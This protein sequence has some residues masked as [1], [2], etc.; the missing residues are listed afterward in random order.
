MELVIKS[1]KEL[2]NYHFNIPNFQR[3][4]RWEPDNVEKLLNDIVDF[5]Q[6]H[7][8]GTFYFYKIEMTNATQFKLYE[9]TDNID[10]TFSTSAELMSFFSKYKDL[11]FFYNKDEEVYNKATK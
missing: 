10:E 2:L 3:G 6:N 11:S 9:V 5:H 7:Q 8:D 4:Y 1:I